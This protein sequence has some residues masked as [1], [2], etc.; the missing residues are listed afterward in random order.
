MIA[1]FLHADSFVCFDNWLTTGVLGWKR[2]VVPVIG[3][4]LIGNSPVRN[5]KRKRPGQHGRVSV[6]G[7]VS[8]SVAGSVEGKEFRYGGFVTDELTA[9]A[10]PGLG[11]VVGR[12]DHKPLWLPY[13]SILPP[14]SFEKSPLEAVGA[15]KYRRSHRGTWPAWQ[16]EVP[17]DRWL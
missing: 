12:I 1:V 8:K 14:D 17:E 5:R 16:R 9:P 10:K 15:R 6:S 7:I 4:G 13:R 3:R 2:Q 11:V